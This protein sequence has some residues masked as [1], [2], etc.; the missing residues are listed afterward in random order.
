[1]K[2]FYDE[3]ELELVRFAAVDIIT[4]SKDDLL[5]EEGNSDE[6]EVVDD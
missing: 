3:P 6:S 2:K 5:W 1:M 4:S